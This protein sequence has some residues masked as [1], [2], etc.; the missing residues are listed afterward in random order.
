[1]KRKLKPV[2]SHALPGWDAHIDALKQAEAEQQARDLSARM[3]RP[4]ASIDAATGRL[5][6]DSPL[7]Y[8]HVNPVLFGE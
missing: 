3:L 7:F 2:E 5:E 6:A 4:L 1:M 8:G